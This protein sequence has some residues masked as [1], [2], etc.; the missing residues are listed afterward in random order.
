LDKSV[1]YAVKGISSCDGLS[2]KHVNTAYLVY[3]NALISSGRKEEAREALK[4]VILQ[5]EDVRQLGE[6]YSLKS[7]LS[8]PRS[9]SCF[10]FIRKA[11]EMSQKSD[12]AILRRISMNNLLKAYRNRGD[13][14]NAMLVAKKLSHHNDSIFNQ[15]LFRNI[16]WLDKSYMDVTRGSKRSKGEVLQLLVENYQIIIVNFAGAV[17]FILGYLF[18]RRI[19]NR[20]D[21]QVLIEQI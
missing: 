17:I 20:Y 15:Q 16:K 5:D 3:V 6:Y 2:Y 14:V 4:K 1:E 18:Y 8:D 19:K 12:I 21:N 7:E 9:D 10:Y 13:S 11:N